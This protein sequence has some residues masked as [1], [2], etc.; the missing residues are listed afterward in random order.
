MASPLPAHVFQARWESRFIREESIRNVNDQARN[1]A[2]KSQIGI[3]I[4]DIALAV[5]ST[6]QYLGALIC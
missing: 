4:F 6:C 2:I 3:F 5:A 1:A